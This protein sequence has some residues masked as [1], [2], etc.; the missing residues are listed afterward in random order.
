M[1]I[2]AILAVLFAFLFV[3]TVLPSLPKPQ[4]IA[5]S[6]A[7][8]LVALTIYLALGSP[9]LSA[10]IA[11]YNDESRDLFQQAQV[12]AG[13]LEQDP[14]PEGKE[15]AALLS[16]LGGIWLQ[17]QRYDEA[18]ATYKEAVVASEG[19]P[20]VVLAYGKA[21]M[22]NGGGMVTKGASDAF[23][24]VAALQPENPE[25]LFFLAMEKAQH[26]DVETAREAM[27]TLAE[28][29][30]QNEKLQLAI[31]EELAK[32]DAAKKEPEAA[33]AQ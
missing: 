1:T 18:E 24:L 11:T 26:G 2:L 16:E 27:N 10:K 31:K 13:K 9:W 28:A 25:P 22:M 23:M 4:R 5:L 19:D 20:A 7:G 15:R 17:L 8:A 21:Q 33:P 12:I 29:F 32:M 30:P 3:W 6:V 14:A